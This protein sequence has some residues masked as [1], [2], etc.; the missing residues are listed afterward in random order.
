MSDIRLDIT[1]DEANVILEALGERPFATVFELV[2]KIQAQAQAQLGDQ[3]L[4]GD[5]PSPPEPDGDGP[6]ED[7]PDGG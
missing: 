6:L 5:Q 1:V 3:P 2:A 4:V 7:G